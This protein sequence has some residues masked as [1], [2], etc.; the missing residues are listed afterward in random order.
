MNDDREKGSRGMG[1]LVAVLACDS[2]YA[3]PLATTLRSLVEANKGDWPVEC[4]ILFDDFCEAAR[5]EVSDSLPNGAA[6]IRWAPVSMER[7]REFS[8]MRGVSTMTFAR[9]LIPHVFPDT[10]T[11]VLY[12]DTD[13][14]V[15]DDI[16]PLWETNLEGAVVGAVQDGLNWCLKAGDSR[17]ERVPRVRNYFNAGVLLIDLARWREERVS[18]KALD[19]LERFPDSPFSD[20]DAI[21][22]ALDGRWKQLDSRWNF[23]DHFARKIEKMRGHERPRI[24]HFVTRSKPWDASCG[25]VNASFYDSYRTRTKFARKRGEKCAD[26]VTGSWYRLKRILGRVR[27]IRVA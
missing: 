10:V 8:T 25:S 23:Q 4:H 24:V 11:R 2:A 22:V 19:Y 13:I 18:E 5:K 26:T 7:F 21:N 12:L 14:L 27:L 20:Q 9:L 6:T 15:L 1:R 16:M 3:M 17:F